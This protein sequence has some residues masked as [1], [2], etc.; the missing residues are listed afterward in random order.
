MQNTLWHKSHQFFYQGQFPKAKE[1]KAEINKRGFIKLLRFV[2]QRKLLKNEKITY[3]LGESICKPYDWQRLNFLYKDSSYS[4]I[5]TAAT[6]TKAR[7]SRRTRHSSKEYIQMAKMHMKRCSTSLLEKNKSKL[8]WGITS[9]WSEWPSP[10]SQINTGEDVEKNE[11][12]YI[13]G[14]NVSLCSL[15]GKQ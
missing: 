9:D 5:A 6:T 10:K 1:I 8:L 2:P 14:G 3:G 13:F 12:S 7:N 4:S 11:P 15:Y